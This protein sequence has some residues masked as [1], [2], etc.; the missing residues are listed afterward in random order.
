MQ[1]GEISMARVNRVERTVTSGPDGREYYR[2]MI[3]AGWEISAYK[4][5]NTYNGYG[6][7][8]AVVISLSAPDHVSGAMYHSTLFFT[9]DFLKEF[10][11]NS[12]DEFGILH[13][14]Y[15]GPDVLVA[16][17]GDMAFGSMEQLEV[18]ETVR[19]P[20]YEALRARREEEIRASV[21]DDP[22][23]VIEKVTYEHIRREYSFMLDGI[24]YRGCF[25]AT[26]EAIRIARWRS[27]PQEI[28]VGMNDPSSAQ[29]LAQCY[30]NIHYDEYRREYLYT[31]KHGVDVHLYGQFACWAPAQNYEDMYLTVFSPM[32]RGGAVICDDLK[33]ELRINQEVID[34]RNRAIREETRKIAEDNRATLQ[35]NLEKGKAFREELQ[36]TADT[37]RIAWL[38]QNSHN[39]QG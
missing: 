10:P 3:P 38:N 32:I 26:A 6:L 23:T 1:K 28:A 7:P 24:P 20:A 14:T 36:R 30:P 25:A 5:L 35:V 22:L 27:V 11:E 16:M 37:I 15:E 39:R 19:D 9:D 29:F 12:V 2:M 13:R 4:N 18:L 31:A 17:R 8:F 34:R 33:E 21:Q